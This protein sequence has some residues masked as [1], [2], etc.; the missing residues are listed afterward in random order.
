M[1]HSSQPPRRVVVT[2]LGAVTPLGLDMESTWQAALAGRSGIDRIQSFDVSGF[3]TTIGG[4]VKGFDPLCY[5]ERKEARR[6]DPFIQYAVAASI[7]ARGAA[8]LQIEGE[9]AEEIGAI[10]GS[11]IGGIAFLSEQL[12]VLLERGPG[13]VS[14]FTVP[15]MIADMASGQ[16]SIVLGAKGPNFCTVSACSSGA[17][18][19]GESSEIIR[20]GDAQAMIAGGSEAAI[21]P[22]GI[23]AFNA[24]R[25]LSR[26]NDDPQGASRPFSAD[27]DGFVMSDGSTVLVLEEMEFARRRGAPILA[28]VLSYAATADAYHITQPA[29]GGEG[30]A[31]AMRRALAKAGLEPHQ[32]DYINAHGTSTPTNDRLETAAIKRVF[33]ESAHR[34]PVSSTKS[35]TGHLIGAAGAIEAALCV[36][37]LRDGMVPPTINLDQADPECDLDYVPWQPR[38]VPLRVVLSNSFGFGGHNSC[39]ILGRYEE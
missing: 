33:G 15:M 23:A 6:T 17:D 16:V 1:P 32:V 11:G 20:R 31:R 39:L 27:R 10:I 36:L 26:R 22:I 29:E 3:E 7:Q 34:I 5:M 37:A 25:A 14:P 21:T 30:G 13:R 4:E 24:A 2:G 18:A 12:K 35:M 19:I 38:P 9:G 8:G 28:E